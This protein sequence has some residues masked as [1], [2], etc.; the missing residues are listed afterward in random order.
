MIYDFIQPQS[1]TL[2]FSR[3]IDK[4]EKCDKIDICY[5]HVKL[6]RVT[7]IHEEFTGRAKKNDT[8]MSKK[9]GV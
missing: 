9:T 5:C 7:K 4:G 3:G 2:Q 6:K 8:L 1:D